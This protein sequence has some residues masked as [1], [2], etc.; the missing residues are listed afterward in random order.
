MTRWRARSRPGPTAVR[1]AARSRSSRVNTPSPDQPDPMDPG[2][3]D[4]GQMMEVARENLDAVHRDPV[5]LGKLASTLLDFARVE[6]G[7]MEANFEPADLAALT[8]GVAAS[9]R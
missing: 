9:F 6:A 3:M 1:P 5:R 7:R 4:P 2:R 8:A